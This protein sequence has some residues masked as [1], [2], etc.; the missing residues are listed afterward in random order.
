MIA[1]HICAWCILLVVLPGCLIPSRYF[2]RKNIFIAPAPHRTHEATYTHTDAPTVTIWIHGTRLFSRALY[3]EDIPYHEGLEPAE[4]AAIPPR[5]KHIGTAL[6]TLHLYIFGWSG[7]LCFIEREKA[8]ARLYQELIT[9]VHEYQTKTGTTPRLRIIAH[10]HGGNVALNLGLCCTDPKLS[11]DELILLACPVQDKT[12]EFV[13]HPLFKKIYALYSALDIIQIIDPQG[14][15]AHRGRAKTFFSKRNFDHRPHVA[16]MKIKINRRAITHGEFSKLPFLNLLP[17]IL[18]GIKT[19]QETISYSQDPNKTHR[20]LCVYTH[21]PM[22][23]SS[24]K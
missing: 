19:W 23:R 6:G 12:K 14:I 16:Q 15:Y 11:I 13:D 21:K 4:S 17:G 5:L 7:K 2:M 22:P 20:V 9:L 3:Q 24:Q 1:K 10:S 18:T 8:A